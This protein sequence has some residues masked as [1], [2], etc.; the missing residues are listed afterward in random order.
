M[1]RTQIYGQARLK[2][3]V[4]KILEPIGSEP[5]TSVNGSLYMNIVHPTSTAT[6][7][8]VE[9]YFIAGTLHFEFLYHRVGGSLR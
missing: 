5:W 7:A 9:K 4:L 1:P 6:R 8:I 3:D 2:P